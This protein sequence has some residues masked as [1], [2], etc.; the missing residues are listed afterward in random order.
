[1]TEFIQTLFAGFAQ[2]TMYALIAIG[3]VI[4]YKATGVLNFT[5][6]GLLM[7]GAYFAQHA[8]AGWGLPFWLALVA[9][10]LGTGALAVLVQV[11]VLSRMAGKPHF[12]L[13]MITWAVLI[14]LEQVP[15]A[16]WGYDVLSMGDP[17]GIS[18]A[19]LGPVSV[20]TIDLWAVALAIAV[21]SALYLF[22]RF[23]RLG[24][25]MRAT[26]IDREAAMAQGISPAV[27][28]NTAW[29]LAGAIAGLAGIF[30]G[31]GARVVGPE[32]SLIALGAIPAVIVGG[33]ESPA[34]AVLGGVLIGMAEVLTA[35]YAPVYA[36]WLGKN[37]HLVMPYIVLITVLTLRPY[38]LLGTRSVRRG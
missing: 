25:A 1:M 3:F 6:G 36:P 2:G 37:F 26:A 19:T 7:F 11:L 16:I 23:S 10:S 14:V 38:G 4:V 20:F 18:M 13:I 30:L 22:F 31:G 8:V 35:N 9:G 32:L 17:W 21:V 27:V 29:F 15:T 33:M 34:G 5:T 24:V 28:F 12:T